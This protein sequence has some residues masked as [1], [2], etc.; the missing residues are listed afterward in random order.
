[1]TRQTLVHNRK[2]EKREKRNTGSG[3]L[4][5]TASYLMFAAPPIIPITCFPLFS[6]FLHKLSKI[7]RG[8]ARH[9]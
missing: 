1:M 5:E 4:R 6:Q 9:P 8:P 7:K 2:A 3:A